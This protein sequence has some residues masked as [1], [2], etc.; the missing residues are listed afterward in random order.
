[1][2][3]QSK[4]VLKAVPTPRAGALPHRGDSLTRKP[5]PLGPYHRPMPRVLGGWVFSCGRDTPVWCT[6][7][8]R[9]RRT[10][11]C[12]AQV[13]GLDLGPM[14]D[15]LGPMGHYLGPMGDDVGPMGDDLGP[16]GDDLGTMGHGHGRG[17]QI[18]S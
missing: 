1:M 17:F 7:V 14:G 9:T 18:Q 4:D 13:P 16:M 12:Q 6:D 3:G 10:R 8:E 5:T 2:A 15:D 11:D